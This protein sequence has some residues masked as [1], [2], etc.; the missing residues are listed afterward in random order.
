MGPRLRSVPRGAAV[1]VLAGLAATLLPLSDVYVDVVDQRELPAT[2]LVENAVPLVLAL[3]LVGGG[4]WLAR[5][6]WERSSLDRVAVWTVGGGAF[7]LLA[8]GWVLLTQAALQSRV[9]PLVVLGNAVVVT[10]AAGLLVGVYD[11]LGRRRLAAVEAERSRFEALFEN[12]PVAVVG[13]EYVD[14]EPVVRMANPA[15]EGTFGR[16]EDDIVGR[17]FEA[18]VVPP[19]ADGD[20][21]PAPNHEAATAADPGVGDEIRL[22]TEAGL[23]TFLR[24]GSDIEGSGE[25]GRYGIYIDVTERRQR[26]ERL[27]VLTRV[28]R[29]NIRNEL[30]VIRGQTDVLAERH[31]ESAAFAAI[32]ESVA[33]LLGLSE[34]AQRIQRLVDDEADVPVELAGAVEDAVATVRERHPPATVE[35]AVPPATT[36][37][38]TAALGAAIEEVLE[39]AVKHG[40]QGPVRVTAERGMTPDYVA[41]TVADGGPGVPDQEVAALGRTSDDEQVE[42]ASGIGLWAVDWIVRDA[43]GEV[44]ID[45]DEGGTTVRLQLP[46]VGDRGSYPGAAAEKHY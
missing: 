4:V 34:R 10:A 29:H 24:T 19:T 13:V 15:F 12:V 28:L 1:V 46:L 23:R 38:G 9:K 45:A 30:T 41:L 33:E 43:G 39:N 7:A 8:V 22:E 40:G 42:H 17:S 44:D 11:A 6:G 26:R 25:A 3:A 21:V 27:A 16:T 18:A 14:G 5:Q 2:T 37:D 31:G 32:R 20:G 35:T 36:V